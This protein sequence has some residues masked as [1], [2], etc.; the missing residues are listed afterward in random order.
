MKGTIGR[1]SEEKL[2]GITN[3][4]TT[5]CLD[6]AGAEILGAEYFLRHENTY[7]YVSPVLFH[8]DLDESKLQVTE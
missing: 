6:E 2:S 5:V 3:S 4:S 1:I 8:F 7:P